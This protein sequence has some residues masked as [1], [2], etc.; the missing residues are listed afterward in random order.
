MTRNQHYSVI[1]IGNLFAL[2]NNIECMRSNRNTV[3]SVHHIISD[4]RYLLFLKVSP[5][6]LQAPSYMCTERSLMKYRMSN[7]VLT[8]GPRRSLCVSI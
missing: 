6:V 5:V 1:N 7:I 8:L 4:R 3:Q 2:L